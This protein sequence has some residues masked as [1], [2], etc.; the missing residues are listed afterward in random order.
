MKRLI[1]TVLLTAASTAFAVV[2]GHTK[3]REIAPL[4]RQFKPSDYLW[5]PEVSPAGPVVVII[6]FSALGVLKTQAGLDP[7]IRHFS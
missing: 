3:G 1:F 7:K 2:P 5:K 6:S 4:S